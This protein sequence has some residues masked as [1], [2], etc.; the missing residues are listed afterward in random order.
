MNA[1]LQRANDEYD[2]FTHTAA[3]DLR[4][5]L[6]SIRQYA[7]FLAEDLHDRITPQEAADLD[8]IVRLS[9]HMRDMLDGLMAYARMGNA[10]LSPEFVPVSEAVDD[11]LHLL[12]IDRETRA[13]TATS[14]PF[15]ADRRALVQLLQNVLGNAVKHGG[16]AITVDLTTLGAVRSGGPAPTTVAACPTTSAS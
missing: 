1:E 8:A 16:G 6:R 5:P 3:H 11:A 7:E 13:I 14:R 4:A 12:G 10:A 2:A 15:C 9:A